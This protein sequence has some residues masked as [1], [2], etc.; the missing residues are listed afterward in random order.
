MRPTNTNTNSQNSLAG[1]VILLLLFASMSLGWTQTTN[2]WTDNFERT[3][4]TDQWSVDNGVWEFG[5]P[6]TGPAVNGAGYRTHDGTNCAATVLAGNY[7][8][9]TS[10]RLIRTTPF[11]V[12]AANQNPR[13]QF[14]HWY[15]F[16]GNSYGVVQ[17]KYGTNPWTD[18]SPRYYNSGGAA[19]SRPVVDLSAYAGKAIQI[20]FQIVADGYVNDGWDVDQVS[21]VKGPYTVGFTNGAIES[22]E[23][24]IG[25]WYDETGTWEVGVPT[26]GPGAAHSGTNCAAT[27][28]GGNYAG[29]TDGRLDSPP[30]VV[31]T[32]D[33]N[34]RLRF[35]SWYN[36]G[37]YDYCEMQIKVGTNAWQALH[38]Y[39]STGSGVWSREGFDLSAYAGQTVQL[40]FYFQS[41]NSGWPS[42]ATSP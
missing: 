42:Y 33:Q 12:P 3:D 40:G 9:N 41:G 20:A 29:N 35:W 1:L 39:T 2:V 6:A 17:I 37:G 30:F 27:V 24:G 8:A 7:P 15:A 26:S 18:L 5:N 23:Q 34:P 28:L 14:W 21:V 11:V 25:D 38:H 31:P 36:I 22:F 4:P 19:W 10:S 13:L 32:A 16:S